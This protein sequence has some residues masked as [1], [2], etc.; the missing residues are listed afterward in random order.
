[1]AHSLHI[2]FRRRP[3]TIP[4]PHIPTGLPDARGLDYCSSLY[5]LKIENASDE[6][7]E[8][9]ADYFCR[10]LARCHLVILA[11]DL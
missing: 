8:V 2:H 6:M 9:F 11:H 3:N 4:A 7:L 1:M 5:R 10:F